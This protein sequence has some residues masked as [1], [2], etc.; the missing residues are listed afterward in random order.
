M[1]TSRLLII[2]LCVLTS[3]VCGG[4]YVA[5]YVMDRDILP[6]S[7]GIVS[8]KAAAS[9]APSSDGGVDSPDP[10]MLTPTPTVTYSRLPRIPY[11]YDGVTCNVTGTEG[12]ESV[13]DYYAFGGE[14]YV[15]LSTDTDGQDY[16]AEG[17]SLAVA[18]FDD[19]CV[20]KDTLTLPQSGGCTYLCASLYDYGLLLVGAGNG[21]LRLWTVSTNMTVRTVG[22]PYVATAASALYDDGA[23]VVAASGDK[24]HLLSVGADLQLRWYHTVDAGGMRVAQLYAYRD[25]YM[26]VCTGVS[27][28]CCH[29]FDA[30]G[31]T[32][33]AVLPSFDAITPYAEGFALASLAD[34]KVYLVD[35]DLVRRGEVSFG[36]ASRVQ[37]AAYDRGIL[38]LAEDAVTTGYLICNHGDVQYTFTTECGHTSLQYTDGRFVMAVQSGRQTVLY[39]YVP[40]EYAPLAVCTY[41]G[42]ANPSVWQHGRYLY[43]VC[44]SIFDYNYFTGALGGQDVYLLRCGAAG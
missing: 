3:L 14:V 19:A 38:L 32:G 35:Y 33:R 2:L 10:P 34:N 40:F 27:T 1:K 23:N 29:R 28:A 12:N 17:P 20:L 16:R 4:L 21:Q 24:M 22:Y 13:L 30:G 36:R 7:A 11:T 25:A 9:T 42:A 44:Q 18:R 39:T 5:R 15:I 31:V 37:L 8:S 41:A 26:A 6:T 43:C